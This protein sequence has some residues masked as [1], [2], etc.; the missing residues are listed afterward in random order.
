MLRPGS[1]RNALELLPGTLIPGL[2]AVFG[3]IL[4]GR[5]AGT[6]TLGLFSLAWVTSNA[7]SSVL[8]EGPANAALR[9]LTTGDPGSVRG[10]RWIVWKRALI[11]CLILVGIGAVLARA[12]SAFGAPIAYSGPWTA[13]QT[14]VLFEA[15]V[16]KAESRFG[17]ASSLTAVRALLGWAASVGGA[18]ASHSVGAAV[19]PN[20][21]VSLVVV[22]LIGSL[23]TQRPDERTRDAVRTIGRPVTLLLLAMYLLGYGDRY[24]IEGI[25]GPVAVGVYTLGYQLGEGGIELF[26]GPVTNALIPRI[27]SE[28][29]DPR[30]GP[31][32]AVKT[33]ERGALAHVVVGILAVPAIVVASW[34][35][36]FELVS[37]H[38]R[39]ATVAAIVAVAVAIQGISRLSTGLLLAQGRPERA[40]PW[41]GV[42]IL[43][44]AVTVPVLT[45]TEGIV[46][47]AVATLIGYAALAGL[48]AREA[49]RGTRR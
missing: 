28:W 17:R 38:H 43:V 7:G 22:A 2:A 10:L 47:A 25:L 18:T 34:L 9:A 6:L 14:L 1:K 27:I 46:G 26:S 36:V 11:G 8:A 3:F 13:S 44:S 4:V 48:L 32:L 29:N 5:V 49:L 19:L 41:T 21:A 20:A 39:I 35:G 31:R 45:V 40:L 15:Q 33:A 16:F 23:K 30:Q 12:G 42:V 37:P 24:V